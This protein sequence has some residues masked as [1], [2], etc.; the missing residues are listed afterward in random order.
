MSHRCEDWIWGLKR[1]K[2]KKRVSERPLLRSGHR[3]RERLTAHTYKPGK[4]KGKLTRQPK[5]MTEAELKRVCIKCGGI[6][7][8]AAFKLKSGTI[9]FCC[10]FN[11]MPDDVA[12][13]IT[14]GHLGN[15]TLLDVRNQVMK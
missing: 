13:K 7:H 11:K 5:A 3:P 9:S 10:T 8:L 14:Y 12:K 1:G 2:G 15:I 4:G 6:G